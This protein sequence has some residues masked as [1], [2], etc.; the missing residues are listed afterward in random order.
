[1]TNANDLQMGISEAVHF[2]PNVLGNATAEAFAKGRI[3]APTALSDGAPKSEHLA[4]TVGGRLHSNHMTI[5]RIRTLAMPPSLR[6]R[7]CQLS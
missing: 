4:R 3:V 7:A 2:D 6:A 1:M 5:D